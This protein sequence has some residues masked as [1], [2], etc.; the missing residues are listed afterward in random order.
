MTALAFYHGGSDATFPYIGVFGPASTTLFAPALSGLVPFTFN[1]VAVTGV[2]VPPGGLLAGVLVSTAFASSADSVGARTSTTGAQG[3]HAQCFAGC[4]G[5][6]PTLNAMVRINRV[7]C[8]VEL[9]GF[10]VQ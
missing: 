1:T 8:P 10:E 4:T 9:Q 2:T 5:T 3:F 7:L 6:F